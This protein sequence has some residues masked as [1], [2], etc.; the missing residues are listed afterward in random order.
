MRR[1]RLARMERS[2]WSAETK[3]PVPGTSLEQ[4]R[5]LLL[6]PLHPLVSKP[7]SAQLIVQYSKVMASYDSAL[8][9]YIYFRGVSSRAHFYAS[10]S[11]VRNALR[12][13][14]QFWHKHPHGLEEDL[15]RKWWSKVKMTATHKTYFL[16]MTQEELWQNFIHILT[17][18][19]RVNIV[20]L[21]FYLNFHFST[22]FLKSLN[23]W[24]C[25]DLDE[26]YNFTGWQSTTLLMKWGTSLWFARCFNKMNAHK[27]QFF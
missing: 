23:V 1:R 7:A 15:I 21:W 16:A 19:K 2:F 27:S 12:K 25:R 11:R 22:F 4:L 18:I 17:V 10:G 13:C 9:I 24:V 6:L 5:L 20:L 3:C 14:L 8:F 26:N